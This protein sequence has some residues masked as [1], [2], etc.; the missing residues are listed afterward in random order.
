MALVFIMNNDAC[1]MT[2]FHV[3]VTETPEIGIGNI[4]GCLSLRFIFI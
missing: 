2:A 4:N 1:A 3:G